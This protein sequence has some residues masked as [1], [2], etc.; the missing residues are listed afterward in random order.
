MNVWIRSILYRWCQYMPIKTKVV[1]FKRKNVASDEFQL[2]T[3]AS[4]DTCVRID[5]KYY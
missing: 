4:F 1:I 3:L 2:G 5:Y